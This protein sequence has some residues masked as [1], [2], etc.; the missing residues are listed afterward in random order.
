MLQRI[1]SFSKL[2][3]LIIS[4]VI[5]TWITAS[6]FLIN[7][8]RQPLFEAA[9]ETTLLTTLLIF[10]ILILENVF[11]YFSPKNHQKW[12]IVALPLIFSIAIVFFSRFS[13]SMLLRQQENYLLFSETLIPLKIFIVFIILLA[14]ATITLVYGQIEDQLEAKQRLDKIQEMAKEAELYHLKQQLQPHFLFNSLNSVSALIKSKPDEAREMIFQLADFLRGT[15]NKGSNEW[16]EVA[17]EKEYLELFLSI[18]KVRFGHRLE[19]TFNVSPE[20]EHLR[21]PQLLLQPILENAIKHGL[22]GL[23]GKVTIQISF[24]KKDSNL[25][26][27]ISNPYSPESGTLKGSG[28]GLEAVSRRLFLIFG[29]NDLLKVQREENNFTVSLKIPQIQ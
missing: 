27:S 6:T 18:E 15:I 5:L 24:T 22:Y 14:W 19:S 8:Y 11:K 28:F 1:A 23:T 20:T 16:I 2:N 13:L 10:G 17:E 7:F 29:R 25:N 12:L 21:I 26:I 4:A 3:W 9:V